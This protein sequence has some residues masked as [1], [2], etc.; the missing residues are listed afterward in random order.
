MAQWAACLPQ[1][2]IPTNRAI[3]MV[4][5][6]AALLATVVACCGVSLISDNPW[7]LAGAAV[8]TLAYCPLWEYHFGKA[9]RE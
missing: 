3:V 9:K 2:M 7:W 8:S 1:L 6:L 5:I 4:L